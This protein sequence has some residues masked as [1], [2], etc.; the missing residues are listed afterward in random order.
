[1]QS[2]NMHTNCILLISS[3]SG[4]N[5]SNTS[6]IFTLLSCNRGSALAGS[7]RVIDVAVLSREGQL[8]S[9]VIEINPFL[10]MTDGV[11]F[12]W[13]TERDVLEGAE[14][15]YPILRLTEKPR[16]EAL[17]MVPQGWKVIIEG[18]YGRS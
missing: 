18:H 14:L 3:V 10:P 1:M 16:G 2:P 6:T 5:L 8:Q 11:L 13:E 12:S 7:A 15:D 9:K 17:V 4:L